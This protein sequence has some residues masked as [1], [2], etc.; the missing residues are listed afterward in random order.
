MQRLRFRASHLPAVRDGSKRVTMRFRDPVRVGPALLVFEFDDEIS[1]P[2]S[3]TSTVA[4]PVG[5]ITDEEAREDGFAGAA[6]V[7]LGLR[8][9]YP[10]LQAG[11]EIV[12]VRFDVDGD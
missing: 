2:G 12:I 5:S 1:L 10:D 6:D 11:D 3:I 4:K 8:D 9:Y 7:L